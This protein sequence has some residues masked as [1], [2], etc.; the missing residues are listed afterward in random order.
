MAIS[1]SGIAFINSY[2]NKINYDGDDTTKIADPNFDESI[3]LPDEYSSYTDEAERNYGT[4]GIYSEEN[5]TNILICGIDN[6]EVEDNLYYG[7]SDSM[8]ILSINNNDNTL[9]LASLS[10][11]VYVK[12]SGH[13]STRL[14][15]A[16][17][18][19]GPSL[20]IDTIQ[21]NYKIKIDN[22]V[23]VDFN[24]FKG[25]IDTFGGVD[26]YLTD[27]EAKSVGRSMKNLGMGAYFTY[28]GE[29]T[30]HLNGDA[31]LLYSR[32]RYIDSD[33]ERTGR[34]RK[35]MEKIFEK[36]KTMSVTDL[37]TAANDIL[38]LVTTDMKKTDIISQSTKI[39][40][41]VNWNTQQT[42]IP[43]KSSEIVE[44]EGLEFG[45]LLVDW[46]ETIAYTK[47]FFYP[48]F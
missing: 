46:N 39:P 38:P 4:N 29:G 7:R 42:V 48:L 20:L 22:Y 23:C 44:V 14:S 40:K 35:V 16:Y 12:I 30:Y 25:I 28:K 26:I 32:L 37:M 18:Y 21:S 31:A 8:M 36:V 41:Y 17:S 5:V 6:G 34:Q 1:I 9:R 13:K 27:A 3:D 47:S 15:A 33:R 2:L 24:G 45:V 19:G 43:D 10:R 11:A